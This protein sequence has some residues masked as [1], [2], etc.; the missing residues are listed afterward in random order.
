MSS[1][2]KVFI[3]GAN[4]GIGLE[5][6]KYYLNKGFT[7]YGSSRSPLN[8]CPE[9]LST[10]RHI[11]LDTS[12]EESIATLATQF[13]KLNVSNLDI[14]INNAG[15]LIRDN[16]KDNNIRA[17]A[18]QQFIVNT[19]GPIS[20]TLALLELL[21]PG[22]KVINITSAMGSIADNSSGSYYG[23]RMSKAALNMAVK[24]LSIDLKDTGV[25]ILGLHP[26]YIKT[27]MTNGNGD[28]GPDES[29]A[30]MAKV[31]DKLDATMNGAFYHRDGHQLAY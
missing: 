29:V 25:L 18:T 9:L 8:D 24:G 26:G 20:T 7:V 12:S 2:G 6:V 19:L 4:R 14:L 15:I 22:S 27:D 31:I 28:M 30:R 1:P 13:K 17:G 11:S 5:F 16:V 3:T 21:N 23:Y 10:D